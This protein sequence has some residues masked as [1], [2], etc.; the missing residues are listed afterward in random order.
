VKDNNRIERNSMKKKN[1]QSRKSRKNQRGAE[2]IIL[3][4]PN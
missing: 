2:D 1:R 4:P 3:D